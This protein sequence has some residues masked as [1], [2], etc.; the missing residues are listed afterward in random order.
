MCEDDIRVSG[1]TGTF[2]FDEGM[3]GAREIFIRHLFAISNTQFRNE[4][5]P[6]VV[7]GPV[8]FPASDAIAPKGFD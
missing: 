2:P 3:N 7:P 6:T 1:T 8:G 4:T 5:R